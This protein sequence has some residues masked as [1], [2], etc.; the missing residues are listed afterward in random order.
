MS[1]Y[2]R[3]DSGRL[4]IEVEHVHIMKHIDV[5]TGKLHEF[6][7]RQVSTGA[8]VIDVAPNGAD[9]CEFAQGV[10]DVRAANVSRVKDV[11]SAPQFLERL[12]T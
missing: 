9:G 1:E 11:L 4:R 3:R 2:D 6:C 5:V 8:S 7:W 12:G 10:E